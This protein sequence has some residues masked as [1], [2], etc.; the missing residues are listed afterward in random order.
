MKNSGF[1]KSMPGVIRLPRIIYSE[2]RVTSFYPTKHSV[3]IPL[4]SSVLDLYSKW[5]IS[6][7]LVGFSKNEL[8]VRVHQ[9][10]IIIKGS[11]QELRDSPLKVNLKEFSFKAL[12]PYEVSPTAILLRDFDSMIRITIPKRNQLHI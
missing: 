7:P 6:I 1:K 9:Q 5:I 3:H 10:E 12:L 8:S 4:D 11:T 2:Q